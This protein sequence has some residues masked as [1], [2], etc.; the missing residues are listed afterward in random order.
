MKTAIILIALDG[1]QVSY[2]EMRSIIVSLVGTFYL[3]T[4]PSPKAVLNFNT[5]FSPE[6]KQAILDLA[7][8]EY[9][10]LI[11]EG[12]KEAFTKSFPI[13]TL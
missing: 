2:S 13:I 5:G 6:Q 4:A 10:L 12:T 1:H 3:D 8:N 7:R 11:I 9:S